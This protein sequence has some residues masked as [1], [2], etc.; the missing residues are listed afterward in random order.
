MASCC[1]HG[2][3]PSLLGWLSVFASQKVLYSVELVNLKFVFW[4]WDPGN[5][6]SLRPITGQLTALNS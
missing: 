2:D 6:C 1:E 5:V 3:E 4:K